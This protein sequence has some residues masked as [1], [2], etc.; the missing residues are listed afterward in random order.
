[1]NPNQFKFIQEFPQYRD[2]LNG[3]SFEDYKKRLAALKRQ[4]TEQEYKYVSGFSFE[5]VIGG[6]L[7]FYGGMPEFG[8]MDYQPTYVGSVDNP[9]HGADGFGK[10]FADIPNP[11]KPRKK[12]KYQDARFAIVQIKFRSNKTDRIREFGRLP[13]VVREF[14]MLHDTVNL[15]LITTSSERTDEMTITDENVDGKTVPFAHFFRMAL[16]EE[17]R[18]RVFVR[19]IDITQLTAFDNFYFWQRLRKFSGLFE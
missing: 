11:E 1:M 16:P 10:A 14:L 9:D 3:S 8:V 13:D 17:L 15:T 18:N 19:V 12:I 6:L 5:F 4:I 7:H 2:I